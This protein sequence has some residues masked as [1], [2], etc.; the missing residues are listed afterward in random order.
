MLEWTPAGA[1]TERRAIIRVAGNVLTLSG[2]AKDLDVGDAVD[3]VLGCN[4]K[5]YASEGGDCQPLHNNINDFG[6]C[7]WIPIKN[8][9]N[10]NPYY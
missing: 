5:A 2:I 7:R 9:I 1:S 8:V 6:G 10:K 4:H 3:V